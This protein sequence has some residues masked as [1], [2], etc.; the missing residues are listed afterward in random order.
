MV[1]FLY[2][3]CARTKTHLGWLGGICLRFG[4]VLFI[5][6]LSSIL[7]GFILGGFFREKKLHMNKS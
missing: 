2:F 1:C 7:L 4:S 6:V 5:K 3:I